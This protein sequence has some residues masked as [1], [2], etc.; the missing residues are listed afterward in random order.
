MDAKSNEEVWSETRSFQTQMAPP[1]ASKDAFV[2][3][4]N[5]DFMLDGSIFRFSGTNAYYL[6]NYEKINEGV[7]E[8]YRV[9]ARSVGKTAS[10]L[11][12]HLKK[13]SGGQRVVVISEDKM[14]AL[15]QQNAPNATHA[16]NSEETGNIGCGVSM[17][18]AT[19]VTASETSREQGGVCGVFTQNA[20]SEKPSHSGQSG[21]CGENGDQGNDKR[22][23]MV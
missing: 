6:P 11:G 4:E 10:K 17:Q 9:D 13:G 23:A 22:R 1:S 8:S 15:K 19:N 14:E 7:C 21:V 3:V 18:N 20:T 5:G 16:T 2:S 12:L